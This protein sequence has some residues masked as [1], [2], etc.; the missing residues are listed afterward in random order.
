VTMT[1]GLIRP[2]RRSV[3]DGRAGGAVDAVGRPVAGLP[4][5]VWVAERFGGRDDLAVVMAELAR[6]RFGRKPRRPR[7]GGK[8]LREDEK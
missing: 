1:G 5:G 4:I 8:A 2:P 3:R 6:E 7:K